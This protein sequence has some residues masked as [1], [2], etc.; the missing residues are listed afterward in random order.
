MAMVL[1]F[2][3]GFSVWDYTPRHLATAVACVT[4]GAFV[5]FVV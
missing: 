2:L 5:F 3:K 4:F 1:T